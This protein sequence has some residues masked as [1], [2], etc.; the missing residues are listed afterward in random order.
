MVKY[1]DECVGC[2]S[3]GLPCH[4]DSCRNRNVPH[5]Y[6][7]EC[8]EENELYEFDGKELCISCIENKLQKVSA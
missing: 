5:F 8:G 1:E 2:R 3:L 4:G 6:C 7:D